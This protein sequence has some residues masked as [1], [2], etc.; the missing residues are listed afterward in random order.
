M[1]ASVVKDTIKKIEAANA[2]KDSAKGT[3]RNR[4]GQID[5]RIDGL[6]EEAHRKGIP[7]KPLRLAIK[8]RG[9]LAK[10]LAVLAECEDDA[11]RASAQMIIELNND[12]D[13]LPLFAA[14]REREAS[15]GEAMA[16]LH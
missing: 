12:P 15:T 6:Y 9:R 4:C 7:S 11:E 5:K 10:A 16:A 2:D 1:K 8:A 14:A 13:D 3:Y